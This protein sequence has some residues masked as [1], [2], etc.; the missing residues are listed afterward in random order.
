MAVS[1][2]RSSSA[3]GNRSEGR[4]R[5]CMR[6]T[7]VS[8]DPH[9]R[10]RADRD[11]LAE[12]GERI[13]VRPFWPISEGLSDTYRKQRA[14]GHSSPIRLAWRGVAQLEHVKDGHRGLSRPPGAVGA[15][16]PGERTRNHRRSRR[17]RGVS[18]A[19]RAVVTLAKPLR[20]VVA[21]KTSRRN[22]FGTQSQHVYTFS[23][24]LEAV[25]RPC[26]AAG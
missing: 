17:H 23:A 18:P 11:R 2:E 4:S 15:Q 24:T 5:C 19:T 26:P 6:P 10:W 22:T 7:I 21:G 16:V 3:T 20:T 12:P 14:G 8:A 13:R 1:T 9:A 25:P